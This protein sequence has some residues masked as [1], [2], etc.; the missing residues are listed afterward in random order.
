MMTDEIKNLP[1]NI[2]YAPRKQPFCL[3]NIIIK[4]QALHAKYRSFI[5]TLHENSFTHSATEI[6]LCYPLF[7][8]KRNNY[9]SQIKK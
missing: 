5:A 3:N 6:S 8:F 7:T 4:K 2:Y 1:D 9:D